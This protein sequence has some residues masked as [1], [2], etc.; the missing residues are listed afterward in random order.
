[1]PRVEVRKPASVIGHTTIGAIESGLF[2]GYLGTIEGLMARMTCE[3]GGRAIGIATGGLASL[4]VP[5]TDVFEAHAPDITL[6]GLK[7]VWERNQ[8]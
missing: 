7:I 3:L 2:Y 8:R 6:Q 5:E 1:L 4:M